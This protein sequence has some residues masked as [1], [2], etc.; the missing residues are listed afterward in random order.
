MLPP[1]IGRIEGIIG[2]IW[3]GVLEKKMNFTT[4]IHPS[5]DCE[6]GSRDE[7]DT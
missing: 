5:V 7:N 6:W 1:K 4:V 3:H 2:D